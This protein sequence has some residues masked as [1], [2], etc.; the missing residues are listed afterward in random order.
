MWSVCVSFSYCIV[1]NLGF[2]LLD[3]GVDHLVS[4]AKSTKF[5]WLMSNVVDKITGRPLAEG[6][7]KRTITWDGRKVRNCRYI[8]Y[9]IRRI[10]GKSNIWR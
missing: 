10:I 2:M 5:P 9:R 1:L 7:V 6:L 4:V 8:I 3:F